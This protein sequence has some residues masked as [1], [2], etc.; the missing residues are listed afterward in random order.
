MEKQAL[1]GKLEKEYNDFTDRIALLP[2][3]DIIARADVIAG[4][5]YVLEHIRSEDFDLS[6]II[7]ETGVPDLDQVEG[8]LEDIYELFRYVNEEELSD[9][10]SEAVRTKF[11]Y[12]CGVQS[13][14][15]DE[16]GE[17]DDED[18]YGLEA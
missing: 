7:D 12:Y 15:T 8:M 5:H 9:E 13:P 2:P 14:P 10:I 18:D 4:Y 6:D 3:R 16:Y 1:I 17:P 11:E